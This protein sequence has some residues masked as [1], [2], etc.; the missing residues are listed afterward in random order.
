[1]RLGGG[2]GQ[3]GQ[4]ILVSTWGGPSNGL[5]HRWPLDLANGYN[6]VVGTLNG[7][8]G[9]SGN[10]NQSGPNGLANT[11]TSFNGS[12]YVSFAS[13]P[14]TVG[15][16]HS[17]F[18]WVFITNIANL[19]G[20]SDQTFWKFI[21][22]GSNY[23]T[24]NNNM[25]TPNNP[26]TGVE[27]AGTDDTTSTTNNPLLN[28]TWAHLGYTFDGVSATTGYFNA[29][30]FTGTP[31]GGVTGAASAFLLAGRSITTGLLVGAL[32]QCVTYSRVLSGAEVTTLF[33]AK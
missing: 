23:S 8:A 17:V 20:G 26:T 15:S 13:N 32:A 16:A 31:V 28:S 25:G 5:T 10:G 6:D 4:I 29:N 22:D 3:M 1:M 2:G 12:G 33:N 24:A 14:V 11:A 19:S 18:C 21:T 30:S 9:G 7:S 27:L